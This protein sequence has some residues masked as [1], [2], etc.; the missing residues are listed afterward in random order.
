M[1]GAAEVGVAVY[2]AEQ[3][4]CVCPYLKDNLHGGGSFSDYIQVG[5]VGD[6]T[7]HWG[8][9]GRIQPQGVPQAD[10]EANSARTGWWM[11]VSPIEHRQ[12]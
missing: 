8:D 4:R 5:D 10:K 11:G 2:G 12:S 7:A 6:D 9:F 1:K 3:G